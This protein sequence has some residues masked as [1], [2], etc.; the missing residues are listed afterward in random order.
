[1]GINYTGRKDQK[2]QGRGRKKG[3]D[4]GKTLI[5]L[6]MKKGEK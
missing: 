5:S 2:E 1:M 6:N 4:Q 3:M